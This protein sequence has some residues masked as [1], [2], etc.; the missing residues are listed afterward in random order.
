MTAGNRN[1]LAPLVW[2]LNSHYTGELHARVGLAERLGHPYEIIPLPYGDT[3]A[4]Q[5]TLKEKHAAQ[6]HASPLVLISGTGEETT[7]DI[8][9]LRQLFGSRLFNVYLASILPEQ[10]HPRLAEYDLIASPQLTGA[11]IVPLT[12]VPHPL[13]HNN[14]VA[15]SQKHA[16]YFHALACPITAVL[17]GGNTRYCTGFTEDHARRLG[18]RIAPIAARQGGSLIVTNSRRTPPAPLAALLAVLAGFNPKFFD[19]RQTPLDFYHAI[20][21]YADLF[22]VTGDSLSMCSE[23]AFTGKPILVDLSKEATECFHREII[24]R[25][26]DCGA[27]KPITG[28]FDYWTYEPI[29]PT[30]LAANAF[31]DHF[32]K[33][34]GCPVA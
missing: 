12:G 4:Y 22:I 16:D 23:A 7:D 20:L 19:W 30:L 15:A 29:D 13:S 2:V 32:Q 3:K 26:I 24:G 31:K 34:F 6:G 28:E 27:A 18:H 17:V 25:L 8:A 1:G 5:Q 11:N 21:A 14:L 10:R 33:K 9:D